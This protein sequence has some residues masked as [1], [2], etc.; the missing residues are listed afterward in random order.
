MLHEKQALTKNA[1]LSKG[2][3][4]MIGG[5]KMLERNAYGSIPIDEMKDLITTVY[6][7]VDDMYQKHT[8]EKVINRLHN[9]K[10]ILSD[11]EIITISIMGEIM[12]NDSEKAWLSFV[13]RNLRDLFPRMLE[14]SRFN[15]VR[16]NLT[17][18]IGH[19]RFCLN[20][21]LELGMADLRIV[22]SA[23]LQVCEFG[24]ACFHR[25]FKG[26]G[27][28][29]GV[30]PSKKIT[31]YG[32]KVHA[33]CA[34][35]GVIT[36]FIVSSADIDDREAVWELVETYNHHLWLI[37]DKGYISARLANDL[38]NENGVSLIYMKRDNAKDQYPKQFRQAMFKIRR[39]I[40]TSFSQLADQFN[41][42]TTRAKS[43][44]GLLCR[45]HTKIL[46]YNLC[47]YINQ[48]LGRPFNDLAKIKSLIF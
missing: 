1:K 44:W 20:Q 48:L 12:S 30:C 19:I 24:R 32:Y 45:L 8:P 39:R 25:L 16:R 41:M 38:R 18:I 27:A 3:K 42:E 29:Y 4:P 14:R 11:S 28:S 26:Y 40:E 47:F 22:D 15:R 34:E 46:A 9:D 35:N 21:Y 5:I 43:F 10:A 36:D 17:Q 31:Y 23:P 6:V 2:I 37:G 13:S 33:L 7:I